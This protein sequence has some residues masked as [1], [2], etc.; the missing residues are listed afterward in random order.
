[1][2]IKENHKRLSTTDSRSVMNDLYY[3]KSNLVWLDKIGTSND[4]I[5]IRNNKREKF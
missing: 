4:E 2:F 1:M 5:S 3:K